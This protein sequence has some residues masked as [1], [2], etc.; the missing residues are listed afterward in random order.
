LLLPTG[1]TRSK[2]R[3]AIHGAGGCC[4]AGYVQ[5]GRAEAG[6]VPAAAAGHRDGHGHRAFHGGER[7]RRGRDARQDRAQQAAAQA[8]GGGRRR[9]RERR[10]L[11]RAAAGAGAARQ[12]AEAPP[13]RQEA[14]GCC[15]R[16]GGCCRKAPGPLVAGAAVHP[17]GVLLARARRA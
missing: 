4:R 9:R 16:R 6:E 8:G 17:G 15:G 13:A 3:R 10:R 7:R 2:D 5:E 14:A 1:V 11:R 12:R